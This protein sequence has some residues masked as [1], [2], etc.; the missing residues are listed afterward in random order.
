MEYGEDETVTLPGDGENV[1]D[2]TGQKILREVE[3]KVALL[4]NGTFL[5]N[6]EEDVTINGVKLWANLPLTASE[7]DLPSVTFIR[8]R[9]AP[10]N[11]AATSIP[12]PSTR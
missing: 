7:A 1:D 8:R 3:D 4:E 11:P 10:L 2:Q 5:N 12:S 6:L 9:M